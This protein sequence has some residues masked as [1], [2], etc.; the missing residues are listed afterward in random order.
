MISEHNFGTHDSG[1][2]TSETCYGALR[3]DVAAVAICDQRSNDQRWLL[4]V[5][6]GRASQ[7]PRRQHHGLTSVSLQNRFDSAEQLDD[8]AS[9]GG[10]ALSG[11]DGDCVPFMQIGHGHGGTAEYSSSI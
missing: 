8:V 9:T 5:A 6:A 10:R 11:E 4:T 1:N 3:S 2:I 7:T